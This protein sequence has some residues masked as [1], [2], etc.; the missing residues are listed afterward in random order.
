MMLHA[1]RLGFLAPASGQLLEFEAAPP[2]D[3]VAA[4]GRFS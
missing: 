4:V 1:A 2:E 3:Y